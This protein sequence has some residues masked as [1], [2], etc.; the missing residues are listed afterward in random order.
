[1]LQ[2]WDIGTGSSVA[3]AQSMFSLTDL[4]KEI[5]KWSRSQKGAHKS[6]QKFWC[7]TMVPT[8]ATKSSGVRQSVTLKSEHTTVSII[9][10]TQLHQE[11]LAFLCLVLAFL[12]LVYQ[13]HSFFTINFNHGT[14][15]V[16]T[17]S[18][19]SGKSARNITL[20]LRFPGIWHKKQD[21]FS[22]FFY[23]EEIYATQS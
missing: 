3:E 5:Q 13:M 16:S 19:C 4:L 2:P 10:C 1:M 11:F 12:C 18:I 23:T 21:L 9:M 17:Q 15:T 6:H 22:F 20:E 7:E 14:W 8:K